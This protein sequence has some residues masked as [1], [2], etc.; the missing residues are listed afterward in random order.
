[1]KEIDL[2][3]LTPEQ[4]EMLET[5]LLAKKKAIEDTKKK[6]IEGYK[7]LAKETVSNQILMLT[8]LSSV[9]SDAK[10]K[11]Y[12]SFSTLIELKQELFGAKSG[13]QS[14]TFSDD[15]GSCITIGYRT[16]D[17]YDDTLDMG[18]SLVQEYISSL[19]TDEKSA[20]LVKHIERLLKKDA[21]GN[22]KP[23]RI[24]ELQ[25]AADEEKDDRLIR[26][27]E[28]IRKSYRPVR[29]VIFIEAEVTDDQGKKQNVPLSITSAD[30]PVGS[31]PNFEV[32]K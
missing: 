14:H 28:I 2:E 25:N 21:R 11:V 30:F 10:A 6:E 18:I 15:S 23:N 7:T 26:G 8:S 16:I 32:F 4:I 3:E 24:V 9:L 12:N 22:L 1:M 31:E 17:N 29:S 5:R 19:A 27:V 20:K 13:Q